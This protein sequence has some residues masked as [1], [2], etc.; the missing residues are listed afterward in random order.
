M[1]FTAIQRRGIWFQGF[2]AFKDLYVPEV[3]E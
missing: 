1:R 3:L 2:L